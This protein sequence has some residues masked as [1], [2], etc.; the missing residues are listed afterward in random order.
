M[1]AGTR[2]VSLEMRQQVWFEESCSIPAETCPSHSFLSKFWVL[3]IMKKLNTETRFYRTKFG[4]AM[5]IYIVLK[6][7]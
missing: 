3:E 2:A 4:I 5:F 1:S 7:C 6:I